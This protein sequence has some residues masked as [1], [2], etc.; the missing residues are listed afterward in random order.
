MPFITVEVPEKVQFLLEPFAKDIHEYISQE[1]QVSIEKCK[2]KKLV[3]NEYF[4]GEGQNVFSGRLIL[5]LMS[6]RDRS[7][8]KGLLQ[9]LL[10]RFSTALQEQ[11][12]TY[13]F[14]VTT[15]IREIDKEFFFAQ[16]IK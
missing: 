3:V 13:Q 12:P 4:I 14:C 6:G 11:N 16:S 15:E 9:G 5:E 7:M 2:T 10:D 1:V 8:L